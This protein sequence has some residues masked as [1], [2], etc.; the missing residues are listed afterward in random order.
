MDDKKLDKIMQ[1]YLSSTVKGK[2]ADFGKIDAN[3]FTKKSKYFKSKTFI[4]VAT[5]LTIVIAII[6]IVLP[7]ALKG[8]SSNEDEMFF[9]DDGSIVYIFDNDKSAVFNNLKNTIV[10]TILCDNCSYNTINIK[11]SNHIIGV[12]ADY[13]LYDELYDDISI[14]V[15]KNGYMIDILGEY[16]K[17]ESATVWE[18]YNIQYD[19]EYNESILQ[20]KCKIHFKDGNYNYFISAVYYESKDI[21]FILNTIYG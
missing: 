15:L 18:K 9:A 5:I 16:L 21:G 20:Y 4:C 19:I 1:D 6:S 10:P 11:E 2:D 13:G 8:N 7:I 12:T 17:L 14:Y 3:S